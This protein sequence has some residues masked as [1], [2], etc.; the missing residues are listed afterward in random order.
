MLGAYRKLTKTG[1]LAIKKNYQYAL[2]ILKLK[3]D[4]WGSLVLIMKIKTFDARILQTDYKSE[5]MFFLF[6]LPLLF[7]FGEHPAGSG[8]KLSDRLIGSY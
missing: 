3:G 1:I 8:S 6:F 5:R 7:I 4:R 2:I